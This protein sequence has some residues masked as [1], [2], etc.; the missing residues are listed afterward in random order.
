MRYYVLLNCTKFAPDFENKRN[1]FFQYISYLGQSNLDFVPNENGF[2]YPEIEEDFFNFIKSQDESHLDFYNNFYLGDILSENKLQYLNNFYKEERPKEHELSYIFSLDKKKDKIIS[3]ETLTAYFMETYEDIKGKLFFPFVFESE[4]RNEEYYIAIAKVDLNEEI[5][6]SL[7][8]VKKIK[9]SE[10]E[11]KNWFKG[12][13]DTTLLKDRDKWPDWRN[14][15]FSSRY[16]TDDSLS[17]DFDFNG[18]ISHPSFFDDI[19]NLE[20]L[21]KISKDFDIYGDI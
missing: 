9:N 15:C 12:E 3:L 8:K 11:I 2:L 14:L 21:D 16:K 18:F 1:I 13:K 4:K 7:S 10:E 5:L 20:E 17:D 6:N 19:F